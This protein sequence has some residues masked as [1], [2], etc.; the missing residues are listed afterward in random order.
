MKPLTDKERAILLTRMGFKNVPGLRHWRER[1]HITPAVD[2]NKPPAKKRTITATRYGREVLCLETGKV[3]PSHEAVVREFSTGK[4]G[5]GLHALKAHL[6]GQRPDYC[7]HTF[8]HGV[9]NQ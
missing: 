2:P 7:G 4:H 5:T 9:N 8:R 3:Y 6:M 1:L